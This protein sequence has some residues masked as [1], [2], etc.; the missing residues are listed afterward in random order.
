VSF[1]TVDAGWQSIELT[2]WI[3]KGVVTCSID[4]TINSL[5]QI[6]MRVKMENILLDSATTEYSLVVLNSKL[7]EGKVTAQ[8]QIQGV[9]GD[10]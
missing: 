2:Q 3:E 7:L 1:K 10:L 4:E 9:Y 8:P 6:E 5:Q